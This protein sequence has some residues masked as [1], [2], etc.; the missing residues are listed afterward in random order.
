MPPKG[1]KSKA[2]GESTAK[3]LFVNEDAST[4]VSNTRDAELDRSKQSHVQRRHFEKKRDEVANAAA[5]QSS[6]AFSSPSDQV[7]GLDALTLASHQSPPEGLMS[8]TDYFDLFDPSTISD[9]LLAVSF[10]SDLYGSLLFNQPQF[11]HFATTSQSP[12]PTFATSRSQKLAYAPLQ[13]LRRSSSRSGGARDERPR[14][15][16]R[17]G[18]SNSLSLS[19][20][21]TP[22]V[23][24]FSDTFL[25]LQ[26]WAPPLIQYYTTVIIPH[27]FAT[28][29]KTVP[30]QLMRHT[31]ALHAEMQICMAEA[32]HMYAHLAAVSARMLRYEG[33]LLLPDVKPEDYTRVPLYFKT[34]AITSLRQKLEGGQV[35]HLLAQDVFRLWANAIMMDDAPAADAHFQAMMEMVRT[36]GGLHAFDDYTKERMILL[37]IWRSSW[38]L[39]RP[40][41]QLTWD[42]G[43]LSED[44]HAEI[45]PEDYNF[46]GSAFNR[47]DVATL[48]DARFLKL[49]A[50]LTE[51]IDLTRYSFANPL[52]PNDFQWL[53]L[54]RTAIEYRLLCSL[55]HPVGDSQQT[56][57]AAA[58]MLAVLIW[59][60]GVLAERNKQLL[61]HQVH[62]LRGRLEGMD[63]QDLERR[64]PELVL[65]MGATAGMATGDKEEAGWFGDMAGR[66]AAGLGLK[67]VEEVEERLGGWLYV[68]EVQSEGLVRVVRG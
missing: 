41:F 17:S 19:A 3:Y 55:T 64:Y 18:V 15:R 12:S 48:F 8:S 36:L 40:Q 43:H 35:D 21:P 26:R 27:A 67:E 38:T 66:V 32:A 22:P 42:P 57:I 51:V 13:P 59:I 16:R 58:T 47:P 53:L 50:S 39:T 54:R 34:K 1:K 49:V 25:A 31:P 7:L 46:L 2:S 29:L 37:D 61:A 4:V 63:L 10:E 68:G 23:D 33:R 6:T 24:P 62:T 28:E 45:R 9:D 52:A 65:W 11:G 14:S 30:M 5:S 56:P 60:S 44:L 20:T